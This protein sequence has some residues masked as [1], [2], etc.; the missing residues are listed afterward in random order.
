MKKPRRAPKKKPWKGENE[1]R[2]T[3]MVAEYHAAQAELATME[4]GT[5]EH[6]KQ[7]K[8]CEALFASAERFFNQH[9]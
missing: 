7:Q 3:R 2:F 5:E 9:Q 4:A 6:A 8:H 1:D